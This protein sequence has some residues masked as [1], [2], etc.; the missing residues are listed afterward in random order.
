MVFFDLDGTLLHNRLDFVALFR[1]LLADGGFTRNPE[2]L[3]RAIAEV[4]SWYEE[5]VGSF[6]GDEHLKQIQDEALAI[7]KSALQAGS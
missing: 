4:W 2:E 3:R 1:S 7:V 5:H 6:K